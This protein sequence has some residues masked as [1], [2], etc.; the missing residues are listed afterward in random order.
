MIRRLVGILVLPLVAYSSAPSEPEAQLAGIPSDHYYEDAISRFAPLGLIDAP[1][2]ERLRSLARH[3][4]SA[5][6][7]KLIHMLLEARDRRQPWESRSH[8]AE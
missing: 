8:G 1:A 6:K 7:R 2:V 4:P 3:F 5:H